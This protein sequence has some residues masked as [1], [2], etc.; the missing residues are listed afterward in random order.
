M[1]RLAANNRGQQVGTIVPT[2]EPFAVAMR[3]R[4]V[5]C[6]RFGQTLIDNRVDS[7][8]DLWIHERCNLSAFIISG[9][10]DDLGQPLCQGFSNFVC[11]FRHPHGG[12]VYTRTAA[13]VSDRRDDHVQ[14]FLPL[15]ETIFADD[16]LAVTWVMDLNPW[17]GSPRTGRRRVAKEQ[18]TTAVPQ[19]LTRARM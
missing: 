2:H 17:I 4:H 13:V 19:N 10:R 15:V 9:P 5:A 6:A 16:N 12:S 3:S 7:L 14:I 8:G 18:G 11:V 1:V